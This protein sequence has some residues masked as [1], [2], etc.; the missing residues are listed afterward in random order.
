MISV[1]S[2]SANCCWWNLRNATSLG[3]EMT[4]F[5]NYLKWWISINKRVF[6]GYFFIENLKV[7]V[8]TWQK[9]RSRYFFCHL[10]TRFLAICIYKT[11]NTTR[12]SFNAFIIQILTL[13]SLKTNLCRK[14]INNREWLK[15]TLLISMLLLHM[16]TIMIRLL[17]KMCCE[18][19]ARYSSWWKGWNEVKVRQISKQLNFWNKK[20]NIFIWS[21]QCFPHQKEFS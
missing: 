21:E 7:A 17:R 11:E 5:V 10:E 20:S 19:M 16:L 12:W 14:M 8:F 9:K 1:S 6:F 2:K 3:N 13:S 15:N 4:N 18:T